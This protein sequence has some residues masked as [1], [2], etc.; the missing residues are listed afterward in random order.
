VGD[1]GGDG[2]E[3]RRLGREEEREGGERVK[4]SGVEEEEEEE[5]EEDLEKGWRKT[6]ASRESVRREG[7]VVVD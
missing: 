2:R 6:I 3:G 4:S 5:E 1:D 7:R